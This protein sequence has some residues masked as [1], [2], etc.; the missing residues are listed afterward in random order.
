MDPHPE[1]KDSVGLFEENTL[2]HSSYVEMKRKEM[3]IN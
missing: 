2:Q 1:W 3:H